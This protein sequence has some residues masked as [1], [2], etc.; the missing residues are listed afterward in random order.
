MGTK[1]SST[2]RSHLCQ[3]VRFGSPHPAYSRF[4]P[5]TDLCQ[6]PQLSGTLMSTSTG[7]LH[8]PSS[9][10]PLRTAG[11]VY[12]VQTRR[13]SVFK[14]LNFPRAQRRLSGRKR[15]GKPKR[16]KRPSDSLGLAKRRA[17]RA[18]VKRRLL[19]R[20][21]D[22]RP[23]NRMSRSSIYTPHPTSHLVYSLYPH[24][25]WHEWSHSLYHFIHCPPIFS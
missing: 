4:S 22:S 5:T 25:H 9:P 3:Q 12:E 1:D 21:M 17:R 19:P 16:C 14:H 20:V 24:I 8:H 18:R 6:I 23:S 15:N 13:G 10:R 11:S 2:A 7:Q